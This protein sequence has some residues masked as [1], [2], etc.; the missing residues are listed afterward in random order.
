MVMLQIIKS[1]VDDIS[2]ISPQ[3]QGQIENRESVGGVER[4]VTQSSHITEKWFSLHDNTKIRVMEAV[5]DMARFAWKGQ[6][7]QRQFVMDDMTQA[8]LDFDSELYSASQYGLFIS[9]AS[10]DLEIYQSLRQL[11][12]SALQAGKLRFSDVM[13]IFMSD[14][15]TVIRKQIQD[16]E[17]RADEAQAKQAQQQAQAS[18][19][20]NEL[21]G[22]K[23]DLMGKKIDLLAEQVEMQ[24]KDLESTAGREDRKVDLKER[25][26]ANKEH[27]TQSK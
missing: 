12:S 4:S 5:L 3:R 22:K 8:V 6:K 7:F 23:V 20:N 27:T 24:R 19:P 21:E 14:S 9:D 18:A 17:D 25:E 15:L 16:A 10:S 2:G 26:V 13:R 1:Q 11:A